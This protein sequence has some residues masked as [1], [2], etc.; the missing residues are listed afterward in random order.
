[1][2]LNVPACLKTNVMHATRGI[3]PSMDL[4]TYSPILLLVDVEKN[5]QIR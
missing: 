5:P 4:C 1:M 3:H 2:F